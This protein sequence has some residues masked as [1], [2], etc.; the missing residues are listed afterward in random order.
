[1]Y[2]GTTLTKYSGRVLG[3]HQKFDRV[4]R[5]HLRSLLKEDND[6]F[7]AIKDILKFEGKNGPD[8]IKQKSPAQNE[9]WHYINPF[10][11]TDVQLLEVVA[12]HHK[13]LV[14][15]LSE[16]NLTRAA[17]E[18]AWL[19]HAVVDGLTPAHHYPYEEELMRLRGGA[20]I[21]T[22]NSLR[23]KLVMHGDTKREKVK[24]NLAM[25]GP[26]GLMSTHGLF[27]WGVATIVAPMRLQKGKPTEADL[28]DLAELGL[29]EIF[30]RR[31]KEVAAMELYEQYYRTGWTPKLAKKV[32]RKLAP[33]IVN[34]ITLSWYSAVLESKKVR[35]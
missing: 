16:D 1:M 17:F 29:L 4:A 8:G 11:E 32:R 28:D 7:P 30:I 22:R 23:E 5:G 34:L 12:G 6:A 33:L 9:P 20:G 27:E 24:N 25:W 26:K 21:E 31:A 2:A 3:V 15:A 35:K 19:A 14:I 13:S 18:A 10:D